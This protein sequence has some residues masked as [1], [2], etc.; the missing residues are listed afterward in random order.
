MRLSL[1]GYAVTG[2]FFLLSLVL[3]PVSAHAVS[4]LIPGEDGGGLTADVDATFTFDDACVSASCQLEVVLTY[5]SVAGGDMNKA[6][7]VLTGV[8]FDTLYDPASTSKDVFSEGMGSVLD[9]GGSGALGGSAFVGPGAATA[10]GELGTDI[11]PHWAVNAN[12]A[13]GIA[14]DLGSIL[15]TSVGDITVGG[16]TATGA[17]MMQM[18]SSTGASSVEINPPNGEKLVRHI[19]RRALAQVYLLCDSSE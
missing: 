12:L 1:G 5:N 19:S 18:L 16:A 6:G 10:S 2:L 11:P 4:I 9:G 3:V 15:I 14:N 17:G 13:F 8:I 7:Q